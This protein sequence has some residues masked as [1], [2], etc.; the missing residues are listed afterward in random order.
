M[1]K[2]NTQRLKENRT[3]EL[4][5]GLILFLVTLLYFG[6]FF[7]ASKNESMDKTS[8][9]RITDLCFLVITP[10]FSSVFGWISCRLLNRILLPHIIYGVLLGAVMFGLFSINIYFWML[11]MALSVLFA[12]FTTNSQEKKKLIEIPW[13]E[14]R[15]SN[16]ITRQSESNSLIDR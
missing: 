7:V 2:K 10:L 6:I 1:E 11:C 3:K 14:D 8:F 15:P 13:E 5:R 12:I 9:V 16:N 4:E